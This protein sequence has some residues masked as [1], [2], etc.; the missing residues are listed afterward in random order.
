[1]TEKMSR[2]LLN[3][4][5]IV[6]GTVGALIA[7]SKAG[8]AVLGSFPGSVLLASLDAVSKWILIIFAHYTLL[9]PE[10]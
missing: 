2:S 8:K 3:G 4:V 5:I 1:M 7:K 6:T 10:K 9:Y